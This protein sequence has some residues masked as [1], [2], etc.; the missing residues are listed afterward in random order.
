MGVNTSTKIKYA[1]QVLHRFPGAHHEFKVF[2]SSRSVKR[3]AC[4]NFMCKKPFIFPPSG[5]SLLKIIKIKRTFVL[6]YSYQFLTSM[7]QLGWKQENLIS[8]VFQQKA[9][10]KQRNKQKIHA[11]NVYLCTC[12]CTLLNYRM[13][14]RAH[15]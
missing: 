6:M 4:Y 8:I 7:F 12:L 10:I 13:F 5:I 1:C 2:V 9:C 15:L 11:K 3:T 14:N